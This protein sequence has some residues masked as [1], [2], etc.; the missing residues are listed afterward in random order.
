MP[1]HSLLE[2]SFK[3]S[4]LSRLEFA[5][6]VFRSRNLPKSLRTEGY[7][8]YTYQPKGFFGGK[9]P[10]TPVVPV[11]GKP[12]LRGERPHSVWYPHPLEVRPCC[13]GVSIKGIEK[14]PWVYH[15][16]CRTARHV[17]MLIGV[18]ERDLLCA[19]GKREPRKRCDCGKFCKSDDYICKSCR[20]KIDAEYSAC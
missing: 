17:A 16:H 5:A 3:T 2:D 18:D 8:T 7:F 6:E 4:G 10:P 15:R 13:W 1:M 9:K 14:Y 19:L 20:V 12:I 11:K